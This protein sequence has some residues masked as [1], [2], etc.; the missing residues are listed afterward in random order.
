VAL[1]TL[2][3]LAAAAAA[4]AQPATRPATQPTDTAATQPAD[5]APTQPA[6]V[7]ADTLVVRDLL[8]MMGDRYGPVL[9]ARSMFKSTLPR[10]TFRRRETVYGDA[11][12]QPSPVGSIVCT[13]PAVEQLEL[14]LGL[15]HEGDRFFSVWPSTVLRSQSAE[16]SD[17][18]LH[19][20][21]SSVPELPD[22]HW[23]APLRADERALTLSANRRSD[24]FM[25]YDLEL[26][27]KNPLKV[28]SAGEGY[29]LETDDAEAVRDVLLVK[30]VEGGWRVGYTPV[31]GKRGAADAPT[32]EP[33]T[34]GDAVTHL[35]RPGDTLAAIARR[36]YGEDSGWRKIAEANEIDPAA[37]RVGQRLTVPDATRGVDAADAAHLA[38]DAVNTDQPGQAVV[39]LSETVYADFDQAARPLVD[40]VVG[41]GMTEGQAQVARLLLERVARSQPHMTI[42]YRLDPP[43]HEKL[44]DLNV[45]GGP[46]ATEV[47]RAA[48]VM[49]VNADPELAGSVDELIERLG[50][51]DWGKR[52]QAMSLLM[53][54][55]HAAR[56]RLEKAQRHR[57]PEVARRIDLLLD[58]LGDGGTD[59]PP[60]LQ[61]RFEDTL[62]PLE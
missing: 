34:P 9:S 33:W 25:L 19:G 58:E 8:L 30:P 47:R 50:S 45:T 41:L 17:L 40:R 13:G 28:S 24:V 16:W 5:P 36:Y 31:V 1:V 7:D 62:I 26:G 20:E 32:P 14:R 10:F 3:V 37:L 56:P 51:P 57:D 55:G 29:K 38:P 39:K 6:T 15:S 60:P 43:V 52:E 53:S 11:Q 23:L 18:K 54:A 21:R 59:R 61:Q 48:F 35:V 49:L 12:H 27:L 22:P 4:R 44:I 46:A 2:I 42:V